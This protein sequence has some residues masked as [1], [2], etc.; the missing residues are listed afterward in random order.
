MDVERVNSIA[1]DDDHSSRSYE[2]ERAWTSVRF[3][4]NM[5][6]FIFSNIITVEEVCDLGEFAQMQT[7][8]K[9]NTCA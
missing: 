1:Y 7:C 3:I 6:V 5:Y 2:E 8:N 9:E 4:D